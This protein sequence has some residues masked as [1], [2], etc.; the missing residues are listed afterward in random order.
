MN[1]IRNVYLHNDNILNKTFILMLIYTNKRLQQKLFSNISSK[2]RC[3]AIIKYYTPN[4]V[5]NY[6]CNSSI[7]SCDL[8]N[9]DFS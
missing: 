6:C 5:I 2:N 3:L 1:I 9:L 7:I 4:Y 8:Q